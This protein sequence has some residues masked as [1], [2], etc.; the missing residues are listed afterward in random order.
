MITVHNVC[1]NWGKTKACRNV[2]F[3]VK[4]GSVTALLG[5]NGA[6]KTTLLKI[7]AGIIAPDSGLVSI[8]G[9]HSIH[10]APHA[11]RLTGCVFE[12]SPLYGSLTVNEFLLFVCDMYG[13][14]R[15]DALLSIDNLIES[16][17]LA[18]IRNSRIRTL[19]KGYCQRVSLAQALVHKPEVLL[20]DEPTNGLD[21]VQL[22]EF[23]SII[24]ANSDGRSIVISTHIMQEV[25]NLCD[26]AVI[27]GKGVVLTSGTISGILAKSGTTTIAEAFIAY[28]VRESEEGT[29]L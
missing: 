28:T 22:E 26:S 20:L 24:R 29:N 19:S 15:P 4:K 11:R 16:C 23:R 2:S 25:E 1:K 27:I 13:M 6:G 3:D 14:S 10:E 12:N 18:E 8:N 7:L 9:I 5:V 21:P 17:K